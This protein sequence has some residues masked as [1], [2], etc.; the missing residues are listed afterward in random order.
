MGIGDWGLGVWGLGFGAQTPPPHPTPHPP[1]PKPPIHTKKI[2]KRYFKLYTHYIISLNIN[3]MITYLSRI[4][5]FTNKSSTCNL[6][7]SLVSSK[8]FFPSYFLSIS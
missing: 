6:I 3:V 7:K 5:P 2:V 1:N 8:K 4:I